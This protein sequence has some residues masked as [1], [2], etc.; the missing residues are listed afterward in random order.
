M[1]YG[2]RSYDGHIDCFIKQD[3]LVVSSSVCPVCALPDILILPHV[4]QKL[5][6]FYGTPRFITVPRTACHVSVP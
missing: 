4:V 5:A 6:A 2:I 3:R 1:S